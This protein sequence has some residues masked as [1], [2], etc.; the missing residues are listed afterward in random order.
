MKKCIP[1]LLILI[2]LPSLVFA[3][4]NEL[5]SLE[6]LLKQHFAKDTLRINLLNA[7]AEKALY[8][9]PEKTL[10]YALKAD[11]LAGILDYDKGKAKS[12][13]LIGTYYFL[14]SDIAVASKYAQNAIQLN[15]ES[16]DK[17]ELAN[18]YILNGNIYSIKGDY[19][20]SLEYIQKSLKICEEIN[21]KAGMLKCYNN[22]GVT[23]SF[24][25]N[26]PKSLES[27]QQSLKLSVELNDKRGMQKCY[28]N[29]GTIYT[30]QRDYSKS[31]EYLEK[32][33]KLSEELNDKQGIAYCLGNIAAN[34]SDQKDYP[35]AL[36]NFQKALKLSEEIEDISNIA[37]CFNNIGLNYLD[38]NDY[39][40]ALEYFGKVLKLA[41][42]SGFQQTA[43]ESYIGFCE[44]Y[45]KLKNYSLAIKYGGKGYAS[46][47]TIGSILTIKDASDLL[48]QAYAGSGNYQKAYKYYIE[49]KNYSDS[50]VN[51]ENAKK[52][53][54]LEYTYKYEQEKEL[55]E[56]EQ[57][58]KDAIQAEK[59]KRQK[60]IR[61]SLIIGLTMVLGLLSYVFYNLNEKKKTNRILA[62]QK[63]EIS[64]KNQKLSTTL[65]IISFQKDEIE[66]QKREIE[67]KNKDLTSS[68]EYAERIQNAILPKTELLAT[69]L[70]ENFILFKPRNIVS[71][72]FYWFAKIEK[73]LIVTVA[74]CTGHGVPG[75][76]MSML[77]MSLLKEIVLKEYITQP[78]IILKK[79]RKEI[80]RALGQKGTIGEQKDGMDISLCSI[81]TDTLEMQWAG[82]NSPCYIVRNGELIRL[83]ANKM[84]IAYFEKMDK[85]TL[86]EMQLQKDDII[87]I[88]SDGLS[89]QFGG[90]DN[91]KFFSHKFRDLLLSI[92]GK[93]MNEQNDI[94]ERTIKEWINYGGKKYDQTDDITVLGMRIGFDVTPGSINHI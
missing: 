10:L 54:A 14:V 44:A 35:R 19:Q 12:S 93:P 29:I 20:K 24:Q 76:F 90:P 33:L 58:K 48:S 79:L 39:S 73:Q 34:Y 46:A 72:D 50:L 57:Q 17:Q 60:I 85:F 22:I 94:L 4:N 63:K 40:R 87:Y 71:G 89:D 45:L 62:A 86:N 36:E 75:A 23:Y 21:Y 74:D 25:G 59:T 8:S 67:Q 92:S 28:N 1:Q 61:N 83:V 51:E 77:G 55:A 69:Y 38:Q 70:P 26:Y 65:E 81:N 13:F 49:Y 3:Q 47:V 37:I 56:A 68:I 32:G 82:A 11:S 52:I 66:I 18:C 43:T 6:N 2:C 91:R 7:I 80:I 64:E 53:T 78:D 42:E 31:M 16:G 84:P 41:E 30:K 27:F 5:D 9:D 88:S 15:E